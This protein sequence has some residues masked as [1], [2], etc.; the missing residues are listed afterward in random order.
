MD[1]TTTYKTAWTAIG[2]SP[3]LLR[4]KLLRS[5]GK[6]DSKIPHSIRIDPAGNVWTVD[7]GSSIVVKYSPLGKKLMTIPVGEQPETKV[8][9]TAEIELP[10]KAGATPLF[11]P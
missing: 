10:K 3:F 6:G 2:R 8:G 11:R 9:K 1:C 7:A 5:W 4:G